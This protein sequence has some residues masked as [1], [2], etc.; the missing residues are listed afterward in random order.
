MESSTAI[1]ADVKIRSLRDTLPEDNIFETIIDFMSC[2]ANFLNEVSK[3][4]L[5]S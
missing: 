4:G 5:C 3:I 1:E 2:M